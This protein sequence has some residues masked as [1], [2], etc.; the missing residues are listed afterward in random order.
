MSDFCEI[1]KE[2]HNGFA[3]TLE[4]LAT[5]AM[6]C[7]FINFTLYMI[8]VMNVQRYMNTVMTSTAAQA[9]RWGGANS[10]AYKD[11][12][13]TVPLM[14]T[15]QSQLKYVAEDFNPVISGSPEKIENNGDKITITI[16][17][18][19]PDVF[20]TMSNIN[21]VSGKNYDMFEKTKEM[22][23]QIVVNSVMEAGKLL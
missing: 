19:L 13:S 20:S 15:A 7:V 9:A 5:L 6:M 16:K 21:S 1:M 10:K 23:M 4:V 2:N 8:R 17:Y 22:K 11:N 3:I 12:V 18:G 14:Q